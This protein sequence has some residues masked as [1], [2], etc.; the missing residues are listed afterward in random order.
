LCDAVEGLFLDEPDT[1]ALRAR[2]E[3]AGREGTDALFLGDGPLGDAIVLAT[4][5]GSWVP[6]VL[7]GVRINLG[8]QPHRHPTVLAREMTTFDR[9]SGGRAVLAFT[10]PFTDATVEAVTV[11]RA[12]WTEGIA[13][14]TG[15]HYPAA[16][17]INRPLPER[18]GGP[19]IALDLTDGAL[20]GPTPDLLALCNLVLVRAGAALP[21]TLPPGV[22]VCEIRDA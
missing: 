1:G 2:A 15:P 6:G 8:S 3:R 5:V 19:P 17:A 13:V 10:A 21:T 9:L 18:E 14:G 12:M 7:L 20:A 16:G 4:A 11:C 22:D